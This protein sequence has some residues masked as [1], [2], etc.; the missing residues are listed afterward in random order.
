MCA[1]KIAR[2]GG[3]GPVTL[4]QKNAYVTTVVICHDQIRFA[5]VV[6]ISLVDKGWVRANV[7]AGGAA[8]AAILL[9]EINVDIIAVQ[10]GEVGVPVAIEVSGNKI[11]RLVGKI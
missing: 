8:I 9:V 1:G 11:S 5:V 7:I 6:Q 4:A 2:R 10:Y 3:E